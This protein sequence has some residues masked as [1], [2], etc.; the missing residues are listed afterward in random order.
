MFRKKYNFL[1]YLLI[2]LLAIVFF[3][4]LLFRIGFVGGNFLLIERAVTQEEKTLG[5]GNRSDIC[6]YCGMLFLFDESAKRS[7]WMKDMSFDIDIIW[8]NNYRVV[9]INQ[10]VRH[11]IDVKH[12]Y[13]YEPVDTVL[14]VSS[15]YVRRNNV[16][17]GDSVRFIK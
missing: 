4:I 15:G 2:V 6:D 3:G 5:L 12:A 10:N 17:I 11:D 9:H 7:F 13:T 1:Q 16:K 8:I 14:E